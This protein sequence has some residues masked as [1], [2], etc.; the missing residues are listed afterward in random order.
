MPV[1]QPQWVGDLPRDPRL[2][3]Y[4]GILDVILDFSKDPVATG[5]H[6]A[7]LGRDVFFGGP[8]GSGKTAALNAF[9]SRSAG[10][11]RSA[12]VNFN[13]CADEELSSG[14]ADC[15]VDI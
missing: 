2:R 3:G 5:E 13:V 1:L 4:Q 10:S 14:A 6:A 11:G 9:L 8:E 15:S 12:R 7:T